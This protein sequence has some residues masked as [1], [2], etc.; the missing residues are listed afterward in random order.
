METKE[1]ERT[2][3]PIDLLRAF[4]RDPR[5]IPSDPEIREQMFSILEQYDNCLP[6]GDLIELA[7]MTVAL[8]EDQRTPDMIGYLYIVALVEWRTKGDA[9]VRASERGR[10]TAEGSDKPALV[11]WLEI[12]RQEKMEVSA[13]EASVLDGFLSSLGMADIKTTMTNLEQLPE[14]LLQ[15]MV[16]EFSALWEEIKENQAGAE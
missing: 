5:T 14:E 3:T 6:F 9:Y 16:E 12:L 8:P 1:T 2:P 7:E 13:A 4:F 11:L 15:E 10:L